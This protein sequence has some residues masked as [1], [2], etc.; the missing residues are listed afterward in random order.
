MQIVISLCVK[1]ADMA[2]VVNFQ[3]SPRW[4]LSADVLRDPCMHCKM[5]LMFRTVVQ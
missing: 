5:L 4:I 1:K 2:T 3:F